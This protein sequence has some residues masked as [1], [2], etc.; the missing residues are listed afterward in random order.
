MNTKEKA[1]SMNKNTKKLSTYKWK[2]FFYYSLINK[3][4]VWAFIYRHNKLFTLTNK[5]KLKYTKVKIIQNNYI[6]DA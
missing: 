2:L 6:N 3:L 5:I 4:W 1:V